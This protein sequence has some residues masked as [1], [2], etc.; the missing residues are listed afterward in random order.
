MSPA[1]QGALEVERYIGS[2][3]ISSN[4]RAGLHGGKS[5]IVCRKQEQPPATIRGG[6]ARGC[7]NNGGQG[8]PGLAD[9]QQQC[10]VQYGGPGGWTGAPLISMTSS[11]R[12]CNQRA[13]PSL[14]QQQQQ[15]QT[16]CCAD[17]QQT[18]PGGHS[19]KSPLSRLAIHTQG[20]PLILAGRFY[21]RGNKVHGNNNNSGNS[22]GAVNMPLCG[23]TVN[24]YVHNSANPSMTSNVNG[25]TRCPTSRIV[26]Q[27]PTTETAMKKPPTTIP[28]NPKTA[29]SDCSSAAGKENAGSSSIANIDSLSIASDESSGSNNSENSLP[30]IIKP[31]KR[32]KKDRKPPNNVVAGGGIDASKSEEQLPVTTTQRQQSSGC[33]STGISG[34]QMGVVGVKSYAP[35]CYEPRIYEAVAPGH[36]RNYRRP[37][38]GLHRET[39]YGGCRAPTMQTEMADVRQ[40]RYAHH[41]HHVQVKVLDDNRNVVAAPMRAAAAPP[42][43]YRHHHHHHHHHHHANGNGNCSNGSMPRRYVHEYAGESCEAAARDDGLGPCQCRY[44][45]PAG[46]IWDVDRNGYSPFLTAPPPLPLPAPPPSSSSS[47]SAVDYCPRGGHFGQIPLF[48][49]PPSCSNLQ[50]R[51]LDRLFDEHSRPQEVDG[52]DSGPVAGPGGVVLRRSWSDPTSYFSYGEEIV[53]PTRDVGVIGDRGG[54]SEGGKHK[55]TLWRGDSIGGAPTSSSTGV[56]GGG[57]NALGGPAG[58]PKGLEVSTEIITSPN[59]HRDLEIKFYSSPSP[60]E[61]R[62]LA[63][64]DKSSS[65]LVEEADDDENHGDDDFSDI[66][67]YHESKLQQDFRTLLQAEE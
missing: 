10:Q 46:L 17:Q 49:T 15:Q 8:Y 59:G 53:A 56:N 25:A 32:R 29:N 30:R 13:S 35:T 38:A 12:R 39:V 61:Q 40:Q 14:G 58:S 19:H 6:K 33:M 23:N 43:G 51:A 67:S 21:N 4:V 41:R 60:A 18:P 54:Q 44:C 63:E 7:Y 37:P 64:E 48:L 66:W 1:S 55:R 9:Q 47:S 57:P 3:L 22:N 45:D 42:K 50:E 24:N 28:A 34:E 52:R 5:A 20:A 26:A 62:C 36:L 65:S 16:T 2:C 31:R 11:P 27:R